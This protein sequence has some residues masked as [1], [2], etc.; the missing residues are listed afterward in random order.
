M[1]QLNFSGGRMNAMNDA[2]ATLSTCAEDGAIVE[3]I[4]AKMRQ[5]G[6]ADRLGIAQQAATRP[7]PTLPKMADVTLAQASIWDNG[8]AKSRRGRSQYVA[9]IEL[10]TAPRD[11]IVVLGKR[12]N[13]AFKDNITLYQRAALTELART[14]SRSRSYP[15]DTSYL[16]SIR[17]L[18]EK[19][20]Y[21]DDPT[22]FVGFLSSTIDGSYPGQQPGTIYHDGAMIALRIADGKPGNA[23]VALGETLD[24]ADFD[25]HQPNGKRLD[26]RIIGQS[27][28]DRCGFDQGGWAT[29]TQD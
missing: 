27:R 6:L 29:G 9:T 14:L 23:M 26:G 19:G 8:L 25:T 1:D 13:V 17:A 20:G 5:S 28:T 4:I 3:M 16:A 2:I 10:W 15:L 18:G 21:A 24:L 12:S 7:L 11:E 22:M